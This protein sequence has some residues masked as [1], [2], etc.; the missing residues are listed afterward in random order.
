MQETDTLEELEMAVNSGSAASE[1]GVFGNF[2]LKYA[3][4]IQSWQDRFCEMAGVYAMCLDA[5][6]NPISR[7]SG[8]PSETEF[9]KKYVTD[10]RIHNIYKRVS[11]SE[12]EDQAV[13]IT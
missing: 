10:V 4:E 8:N 13:E 3:R 6:G 9:I 12:L 7:F 1:R 5:T 11:E 2:A